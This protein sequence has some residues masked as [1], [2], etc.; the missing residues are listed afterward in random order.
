MGKEEDGGEEGVVVGGSERYGQRSRCPAKD[1]IMR[2]VRGTRTIGTTR[3]THCT[4]RLPY[5]NDQSLVSFR[6]CLEH[7]S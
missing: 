1:I 3:T 2:N 5:A 4:R 7:S 6:M